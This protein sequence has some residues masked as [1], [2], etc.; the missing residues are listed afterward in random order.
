MEK[1]NLHEESKKSGSVLAQ[2]SSQHKQLVETNR[3]YLRTLSEVTLFLCWQGLAFRSHDE[4]INS[5]NQ[6]RYFARNYIITE[7]KL[8]ITF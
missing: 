1:W 7:I 3:M 8:K 4:S 6:G 5:M 2:I